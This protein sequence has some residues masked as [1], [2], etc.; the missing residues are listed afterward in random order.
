MRFSDKGYYIEEYV[1][2]ANCGML[3]YGQ[4]IEGSRGGEL[5]LYC[6]AWCEEWSAMREAGTE[7][8]MLPL[9]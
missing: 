8:M 9:R 1:K 2:C 4:G 3:I 5:A 6:S 7:Q